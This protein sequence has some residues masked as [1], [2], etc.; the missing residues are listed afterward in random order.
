[1]DFGK[2]FFSA[3]GRIGRQEF[4]VAWVIL[5]AVGLFTAIIPL[6][7]IL[8]GLGSIYCGVCIRSKRLHDMGRTGW[9]QLV[10]HVARVFAL[11]LMFWFVIGA[12]VAGVFGDL[13]IHPLATAGAIAGAVTTVVTFL[14]C[15]LINLAFLLWIGIAEGEPYDNIH[16]PVPPPMGYSSVAAA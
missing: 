12:I 3:Y 14:L 6:V 10:P 11:A 2:L 13:L 4:W 5:F 16:G 8:V 7:N 15:G 9:W 1:M